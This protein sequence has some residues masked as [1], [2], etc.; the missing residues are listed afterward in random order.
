M[1]QWV[2]VQVKVAKNNPTCSVPPE[3]LP[4]KMKKKNF[5]FD[6]K[7]CWIHGGFEQFS[8]SI[9][10]RV[11]GLQS[12]ARNVAFAGLKRSVEVTILCFLAVAIDTPVDLEIRKLLIRH[13]WRNSYTWRECSRLGRN[14]LNIKPN[15]ML[16]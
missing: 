7:T 13:L 5:Y 11:I 2:G 16:S 4:P 12:S 3:N 10:W 9:A 1:A 6:N 15:L 8:S 14:E